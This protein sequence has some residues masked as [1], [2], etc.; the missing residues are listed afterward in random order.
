MMKSAALA[1]VALSLFASPVHRGEPD[2]DVAMVLA[3]DA[4]SSMTG[5]EY[6]LQRDGFAEAFRS[7]RVHRAIQQGG[8][9]RIAVTYVEWS[10]GD[11]QTVIIPW[12]VIT[13]REEAIRFADRISAH[14]PAEGRYTSISGAMTF[15]AALFD[16]APG[17]PMRRVIDIS[18]DGP[19]ND[20]VSVAWARDQAIA[21]GITING[22]P[23]M[24]KP[25]PWSV[26]G[27]DVYLH[28]V[29]QIWDVEHLDAYYRDCVIGGPGAFVVPVTDTSQFTEAI[30]TK[31]LLEIAGTISVEAQVQRASTSER[32][33]CM[34]GELRRREDEARSIG[35]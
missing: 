10:G 26:P 23:I 13:R 35:P 21:A 17:R 4:S 19:N 3:V 8:L 12:T 15:S 24:T 16:S 9:G 20:G 7:T 31:V 28:G 27:Y 18:G 6:T 5:T 25:S 11:Q 2:L 29:K 32:T 34:G 33:N 30:T 1:T 14:H 22:L